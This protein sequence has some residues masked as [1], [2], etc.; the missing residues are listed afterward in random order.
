MGIWEKPL[1]LLTIADLVQPPCF[2]MKK[3]KSRNEEETMAVSD[4]IMNYK[5]L[6][7]YQCKEL[8]AREMVS[9]N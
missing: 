4:E 9:Q 8:P 6:Y 5:A 1:V 7:T 3:L 2:K